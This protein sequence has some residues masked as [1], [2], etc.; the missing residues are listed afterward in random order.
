MK[1]KILT[2]FLF[3]IFSWI[4]SGIKGQTPSAYPAATTVN[5]IRSWDAL[6]PDTDPVHL[7]TRP[8]T[9]VH[10]TTEYVDGLGRSIQSVIKQISPSG[11]DMVTAQVYDAL[12]RE[13]FKYLPFAS[14]TGASVNDNPTDGNFKIDPFQQQ[15]SF[16]QNQYP[17][18]SNF[19]SQTTYEPSPLNRPQTTYA[20]GVNWVG[21]SRGVSAQ[22]LVNQASDSVWYWTIAAAPGSI[23]V[24]TSMYAA[25]ALYKNQTTDEQAH[26]VVEYKDLQGKVVLKK[27]QLAATPGTAHVGWLST[28]YVYDDLNNLRFVIQPKAVDLLEANGTWNLSSIT[29]LTDELCFRYEYDYRKR[30]IIKKIPGAGE[31]WMVYDGRDRLVMTQDANLRAAGK[32]LVTKYDSENRPDSTGLLTDANNRAYHQNLSEN[33]SYYP[34]TISNFELLSRS[35]YDDYTWASGAGLISSLNTTYTTNASYFN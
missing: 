15:N 25:G 8:L 14:N 13:S 28:Y 24:S 33:N 10:Q 22:Y 30:M 31:V 26:S 17:S 7:I 18:E 5:Y 9:D 12:G 32:W 29:S 20:P 2:G 23:P 35:Y 16:S 6:A 34:S 21:A 1:K 19:Y 27:V 3:L 11:K 4:S